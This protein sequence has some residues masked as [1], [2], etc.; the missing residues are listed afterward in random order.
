[1]SI[2]ATYLLRMAYNFS[3]MR[4]FE[5]NFMATVVSSQL[6]LNSSIP[7]DQFESLNLIENVQPTCTNRK[8]NKFRCELQCKDSNQTAWPLKR[9]GCKVLNAPDSKKYKPE[10]GQE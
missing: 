9:I 1:M 10:K 2:R 8:G 3:R 6:T 4:L 7:C 5:I